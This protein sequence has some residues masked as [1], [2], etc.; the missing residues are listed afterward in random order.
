[1]TNE[2][3][4]RLTQIAQAAV[5]EMSAD[6]KKLVRE[7]AKELG[8]EIKNTRCK[9]CMKDA[10][11]LCVLKIRE[12]EKEQEKEQ[13]AKDER[14][15]VLK[16]GVDVIFGYPNGVRINELTLTDEL[17]CKIMKKGFPTELFEKYEDNG[18]DEI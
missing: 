9:S 12:Q 5:N 2:Q 16:K 4:E 10:A 17:A 6:D 11:I 7:C 1:M 8:V 18:N 13:A 14:K 15:F 3:K